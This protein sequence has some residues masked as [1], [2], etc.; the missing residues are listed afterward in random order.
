VFGLF[1]LLGVA[2]L[3]GLIAF[4]GDR[5]GMRVGRKRLTL[6]GLR[7]RYT[8]MIIAVMTGVLA[9]ISTLGISSIV[10]E[11]VRIA[12]FHLTKLRR[13]LAVAQARNLEMKNEYQRVTMALRQVTAKWE[14]AR[15]D[16]ASTTERL[17]ALTAAQQKVEEEL[18][19]AKE[20]LAEKTADLVKLN[21]EYARARK[22]REEA[23][24]EVK[25]FQQRKENLES[26]IAILE[27]QIETLSA[28]REYLGIGVVDFATRPIILHVGEVL[29]AAVVRPGKSFTAT[30]E[31]MVALLGR[32][33][34]IAKAR[35]AAIEGK[36]V[37]TRVDMK[38]VTEA[39][40]TLLKLQTPA[41]VRVVAGTNVVAG[42]PAVIYP[43][44][45]PDEIVFRRG[46]TVIAVVLEGEETPEV[47]FARLLGEV[48]TAGKKAAAEKGMVD[49]EGVTPWPSL[50]L[51]LLRE[52]A[53]QAAQSSGR[54]E[55]KFIAAR[56]LHRA[57]EILNLVPVLTVNKNG[58]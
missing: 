28:Q 49:P 38:R 16:L 27:N 12:L 31:L 3:G 11:N 10:S 55:V 57:G 29:A 53:R 51:E 8:S 42:K 19:G 32:A 21:E 44:V 50:D 26:A 36:T 1:L 34:Q 2:A 46:E 25:F 9:A 15:Q 22:E 30:E 14:T 13:D 33:D 5:V 39:Y 43:E 35:G 54:R 4:V 37:A 17:T 6:F 52:T 24:R 7:P 23:E 56:D 41:V 20:E 40:K 18:R 45:L 48:F 47:L 58:R